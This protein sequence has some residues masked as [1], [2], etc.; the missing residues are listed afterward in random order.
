MSLTRAGGPSAVP[1]TRLTWSGALLSR[2]VRDIRNVPAG[3]LAS[4]GSLPVT[5][6]GDGLQAD[7]SF[8]SPEPGQVRRYML[9]LASENAAASPPPTGASVPP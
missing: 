3:P 6:G 8:G 5:G 9:P 4:R 2:P 7:A 1:L